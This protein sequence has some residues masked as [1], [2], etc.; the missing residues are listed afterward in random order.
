V[1]QGTGRHHFYHVVRFANELGTPNWMEPGTAQCFV[2]RLLTGNMTYG[3]MPVC[4]YYS[5]VNPQCLLVWGHNPIISGPDGEIRFRVKECMKKGAK[6]IVVDPRETQMAKEADLWLQVRPGTD[7]ALA[8]GML[9]VI[10]D[11]QL[12]DKPFVEQWTSGF[13]RL[14]ERVRQY[15]PERVAAITWIPAPQIKEA[16]HRFAAVKP[17]ALEWGVG[18]EQSPNSLQTV[19]AVSLL[20]ALTGNIDIPGG[21]VL[22]EQ[23]I[24]DATAFSKR[25]SPEMQQKRLGAHKYKVLSGPESQWPSAHVPTVLNAMR[26]GEPYPVTALLNFGNNGLVSYADSTSVYRTL[27][28]LDFILAMDLYMTPTTQLADIVL[29][30]VTWLELD[31]LVIAP[32]CAPQVILAQQEIV[33]L[34]EGKADEEVMLELIHRLNPGSTLEPVQAIL[35]RQLQYAAMLEKSFDGI[36]FQQLKQDGFI[37]V[38]QRYRKYLENGFRTESGKIELAS[39]YLER[40]GYDPVPYYRE[41]PESPLSTPQRA[42]EF[43]LILITGGRSDNFFHSEYRQIS[44]LRDKEPDPL[45]EIHPETAK[46][47]HI[48][49]GDWIWIETLRGKIKQKARLTTGIHPQ[50]VNV[51]HGWWFPEKEGPEYGIWESNANMLTDNGP[52]YD[53]AMGTYQLRALLCKIY[54]DTGLVGP[55]TGLVGP[56][57][58]LVNPDTGLDFDL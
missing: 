58:G 24:P 31:Q 57:T 6:L 19:R 41:P 16:A 36:T 21:W 12:Y 42:E 54:P 10:I 47:L 52:P 40:L 28:G 48:Q 3:T 44:K 9:N 53:P 22:G 1:G 7:D 8:L 33:R 17:A 14:A 29:P 11:E 18:L 2:P 4:D 5:D 43:P 37:P 51:Q 45:V 50:V 30:A 15:N 46:T 35:D 13:D 25:L 23:V 26:T 55:D 38:P 20:P 49:E 32:T 27:M 39:N 56:D 34:H